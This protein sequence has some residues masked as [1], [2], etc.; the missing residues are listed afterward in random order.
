MPKNVSWI[1]IVIRI[2]YLKSCTW[3]VCETLRPKT[4]IGNF[5]VNSGQCLKNRFD[6]DGRGDGGRVEAHNNIARF[7]KRAMSMTEVD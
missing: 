1:T 2:S 6:S 5:L 3:L 7:Q 4:E